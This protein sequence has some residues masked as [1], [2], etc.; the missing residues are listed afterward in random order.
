MTLAVPWGTGLLP[1]MSAL[2]SEGPQRSALVR[3]GS[4]SPSHQS[5]NTRWTN[6]LRPA[7]TH[8]TTVL[9]P[10][11]LLVTQLLTGALEPPAE[12]G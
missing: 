3:T 11:S 2:V 1:G 4:L 9:S 6:F 8:L 10:E 12:K 7:S 5:A